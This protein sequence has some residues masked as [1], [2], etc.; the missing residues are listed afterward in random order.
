M[1]A[2]LASAA[3]RQEAELLVSLSVDIL[4]LK[5]PA[6]GALGALPCPEVHSIV[7]ALKPQRISATVGDLP[8]DPAVIAPHV[9]AMAATAVDFIKVGFFEGGDWASVLEGLVPLTARGQALVAVLFA[10]QSP[11]LGDL[12]PFSR[13][14]FRGVMVDTADKSRGRLLDWL[15]L[16]A[17]QAFVAEAKALDLLCGLSGSLR[18][19]DVTRLGPLGADYLGFRGA[20]CH[21]Q[22]TGAIDPSSVRLLRQ[23]VLAG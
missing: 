17:L 5:D 22:R 1:T 15:S 7:K 8:M 6:Q 11:N 13:A 23:A 4:D 12:R 20:L 9:E 3:T 18:L 14:G 10:D 16:P 2:L 21:G 19:D